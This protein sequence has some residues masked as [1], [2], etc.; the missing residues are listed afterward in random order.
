M[1][2]R[3]QEKGNPLALL[4]GMQT[5][6][7]TAENSM[8]HLRKLKIELPN[9]PVIS[10]LGFTKG[11]KNTDLKGKCTPIFVAALS[12]IAKLSPKGPSTYDWIM[13]MWSIYT[14]DVY[15]AIEK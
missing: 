13:R 8:G 7:P 9:I 3:M 11:Y 5:V 6:A 4:V 14:M 1:L 12:A 2:A 15:S 10:L